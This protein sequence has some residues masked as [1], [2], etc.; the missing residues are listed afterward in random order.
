MANNPCSGNAGWGNGSD[1]NPGT[2]A[3]PW[4]T[5]QYAMNAMNAGDT[6]IVDQGTYT[7]DNNIINDSHKPKQGSAGAYTTI[8]ADVTGYSTFDGEGARNM[9]YVISGAEGYGYIKFDG[10]VWCRSASADNVYL[11]AQNNNIKIT[12]IYFSKCGFYDSNLSGGTSGNVLNIRRAEY[13]LVEN[14]YAWGEGYYM[15][16]MERV[17]YGIFRQCVCR[18][19]I[20]R[21]A[22]GGCFG[23]YSSNYIEVQNCIAIDSDNTT[24]YTDVTEFLCGY[25]YPNTDDVGTYT[26]TIGSIALNM[27][28]SRTVSGFVARVYGET[29]F[30]VE[31]TI[32]WDTQGGWWDRNGSASPTPTYTHCIFGDTQGGA[33]SEGIAVDSGG[34]ISNSII[35]ANAT[36]GAKIT[37]SD[38]NDYFNNG[39]DKTSG[40]YG[41]HDYCAANSPTYPAIN[42]LAAGTSSWLYIPRIEPGSSL[43]TKGSDGGRI[44]PNIESKIGTIGTFYGDTG[45][46]ADTGEDLWPFPYEDL[47]KAKFST[48]TGNANGTANGARGFCAT[49]KQLNG[50]DDITLTSYIWEYLGNQM[51]SDIYSTPTIRSGSI[52]NGGVRP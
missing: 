14:C 21:G 34:S 44:G 17:N 25:S 35:M 40:G 51:P 33:I 15:M 10:L 20:H 48:Y 36:T 12:H 6:L 47:I 9:F 7:G 11:Q 38:Y 8:Q 50:T 2:K 16:Y 18:Y 32:C 22:R 28:G 1:S 30:T 37:T 43:A 49:G 19:D 29:Y 42:P 41:A 39:T 5:L 13:V 26:H 45:Y 23:V 4:L 27:Q 3:E 52:V 31:D 46:D 24:Y